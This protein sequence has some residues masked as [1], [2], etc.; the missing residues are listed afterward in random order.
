MV[1]V[2]HWN[3]TQTEHR[4]NRTRGSIKNRNLVDHWLEVRQAAVHAVVAAVVDQRSERKR[5]GGRHEGLPQ[6]IVRLELR[7]S[8]GLEE[9]QGGIGYVQ[10]PGG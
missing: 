8:Y 3:R 10:A 7:L 4:Q 9:G 6:V 2:V 5:T 1:V